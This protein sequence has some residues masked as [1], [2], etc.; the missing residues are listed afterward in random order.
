MDNTIANVECQPGTCE[1]VTSQSSAVQQKLHYQ[2]SLGNKEGWMFGLHM[3]LR[4]KTQTLQPLM[5]PTLLE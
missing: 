3:M 4:F 1:N 5:Q 2:G